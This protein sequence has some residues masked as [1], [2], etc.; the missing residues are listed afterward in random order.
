MI[1]KLVQLIV[2][3]GCMMNLSACSQIIV[4]WQEEVKLND[5]RIIVVEQ[6]KRSDGRIAREAWLTI[7]LPEFSAKPLVW[8]ENLDPLIL[9]VNEGRLYVVGIPPTVREARLYGNPTPPYIGFLWERDSWK[10]IPFE[11]IPEAIYATNMLIES[12][13]P[14]DTTLLT[15]AKKKSVEVNG[16]PTL[17][18]YFKRIDPTFVY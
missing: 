18:K 6:K 2:I 11:Q 1:K 10:R 16:D 17:P 8:H 13:P 12:F 15:L 9:N 7:N 3:V 4:T 5:G 14:K